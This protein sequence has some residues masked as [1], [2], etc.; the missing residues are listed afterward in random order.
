MLMIASVRK[1]RHQ[2]KIGFTI[3][4]VAVVSITTIGCGGCGISLLALAGLSTSLSFLPFKGLELQIISATLLSSSLYYLLQK[5]HKKY[6]CRIASVENK[7][8]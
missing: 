1:L 8:D 7:K 2:G 5:L 6:Y 3:G 4:G